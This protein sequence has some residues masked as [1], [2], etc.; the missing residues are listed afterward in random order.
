MKSWQVTAECLTHLLVTHVSCGRPEM[1]G[2]AVTA[3]V[4]TRCPGVVK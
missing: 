1:V 2:R 3:V 4:N